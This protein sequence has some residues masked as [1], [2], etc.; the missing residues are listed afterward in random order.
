MVT[1]AL[2]EFERQ[3]R[4]HVEVHKLTWDNAWPEL[5][6]ASIYK[7]GYDVS[8]IGTTWLS[9]FVGLN[10]LR[11]FSPDEISST[12]GPSAFLKSSWQTTSIAGMPETWAIPW[13]VDGRLLYYRRDILEKI[14]LDEKDAFCTDQSIKQCLTAM[15]RARIKYPLVIPTH[16]TR[17]TLHNAASWV[18]GAGGEF[19]NPEGTRVLFGSPESVE[20][21][22]CYFELGRYLRVKSRELDGSQSD[23]FFMDGN[24]AVTISGPWL[25]FGDPDIIQEVGITFPP[26]QPFIGGSNLVIW[27]HA[28]HWREGLE[29]V[30][31]LT[32]SRIQE[33]YF[34]KGGLWPSR[35]EALE[36]AALVAD[37][38][39]AIIVRGL[40]T[41]R[42]FRPMQL[43]G[44]IE[45]RLTNSLQEIWRSVLSKPRA[46]VRPIVK[47]FIESLARKTNDLLLYKL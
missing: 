4:I 20:G 34:S 8:E 18:W 13:L 36:S 14:G 45:E 22:S 17:N 37:P 47:E 25:R 35:L 41:G 16:K 32:D 1:P 19:A 11:P 43:W 6:R 21:L 2:V 3:S 24:A 39:H 23:L 27:N 31:F 9:D 40:Q 30:R 29:L 15:A 5:T 38:I 7:H 28:P 46:D 42:S 12:G 44:L 33:D 10:N 26:G